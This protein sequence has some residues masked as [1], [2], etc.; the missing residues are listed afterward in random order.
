MHR[1]NAKQCHRRLPIAKWSK[2]Y[3]VNDICSL[4]IFIYMHWKLI[5]KSSIN[6]CCATRMTQPC[7][8]FDH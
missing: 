8:S 5:C 3:L 6:V 2:L 7:V 4:S 1:R